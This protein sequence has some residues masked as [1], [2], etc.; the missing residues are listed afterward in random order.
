MVF[1]MQNFKEINMFFC[2]IKLKLPKKKI[3]SCHLLETNLKHLFAF[4]KK[5]CIKVY[6][7][8]TYIPKNKNHKLAYFNML[9]P[10]NTKII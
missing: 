8:V 10:H 2:A 7:M 9:A 3:K 5:N 6:F 1:N 4:F